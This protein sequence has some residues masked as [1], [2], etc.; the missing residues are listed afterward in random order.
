MSPLRGR[1]GR[2]RTATRTFPAGDTLDAYL[3]ST[4]DLARVALNGGVVPPA[5]YATVVPQPGDEIWLYPAWAD[6]GILLTLGIGLAVSLLAAT[7]S[8]FLFRPKPLLL[9]QQN[10]MTEA[11]EERTF[12][13]EGIRTAIG[14][15]AVVPV[16]Y[17]RHRI[18][19]QLLA[20]AVD[21]AAVYVDDHVVTPGTPVT[22]VNYGEPQ[23]IVIVTAPGH[24]FQTN[25]NVTLDGLIGKPALN[26][27]WTIRVL[28]GDPDSFALLFSWGVNIETPYGGGGVARPANVGARTVQAI[29]TPP[30]LSL[31]LGLCE[32]PIS[33]VLT[34]TIQINGQPIQNFPGVQVF[35][36]LGTA[37][38]PAFAEFGAPRNTFSDGRTLTEEGIAVTYTSNGPLYA[39]VLNVV[40]E[41]GLFFMNQKGEK[42]SNTV[43]LEYRYA[44]AGT[45]NWSPVAV[46][47]VTGDRTAPV[48][49]GLKQENLPFAQYD[50]QIAR[51]GATQTDEVRAKFVPTLE[52]VT[53]YIPNTASYPYTAWLG[54][55]ALATDSLR[56][57]LPN[58]TVEVLGR[59]VRVATLAPVATWSDNPSWCIMDMLTN[60]RYGRGVSDGEIDLNAF[61]LYALNCDQIIDG[62]FR[63]RLNIVLDRET[64]AQQFFLE[65]MGGSRG[66]LLKSYG[67]WTP[68]PTL[69]EPPVMLL[70][71]TMVSN[72]TLT[73]LRDV[74]AI[75]VMEA[76]FANEDA[77]FEQDVLTWPTIQNWPPE[78]HKASL[79]L[80]GV[81]KPSR[82]MRA[83]QFELNRR[84]YEN[85]LLELD[86]SAEAL[87]LQIHDLFRFSHPLPGWGTSGRT[88]PGST[89]FTL[90]LDEPCTFEPGVNYVVY[91]RYENDV[92]EVRNVIPTVPSPV[93]A[94]ILTTP[95]S[96]TPVP[97]TT[98]WVFGRLD[99]E[100]N[101]RIF[102]VTALQRKSDTTVHLEAVI[103]NP[104]IYDDPLAAPL[105]VITTLFNPLGPP[106]PLVTL[107]ATEVTRI[108]ASGASLRVVNLSWDIAELGSGL[109][110][111]G[112]AYIYRRSILASG[113]LGQ[114]VAGT[115]DLGAIVDANDPNV[116]YV[117]LAQVRG[118]VLDWDDATVIT[119]GTYQYR[120]VPVS[121]LGVP[122]N[123]GGREVLIHVAGPTTPGYFPGTPRNL[124]LKGQP[125]GVVFWEGRDCHLEWDPV[126]TSLLFSETFFVQDYIVQIWAP[127]QLYLMRATTVPVSSPGQSVQWSYTYEQN[128]EDEVRGGFATARRDFEVWVWARTN[129]GLL[130]QTPASL[131]VANPAPDM[132]EIVPDVTPLFE[133][134][135]I[136]FNQYAEP[137]DFHHYEVHLDVVNPPVV[138][139][140][141]VS[142]AFRKLFPA[143]LTAGTQ[144]W[145]YILPYDTF[146]PGIASQTATFTPV[147]L[148]ADALDDTPPSLPTGLT[149]TTGSTVNPDGTI[150]SWVRASWVA[151]PESDVA[152]YE[153]HFRIL[154]SVVPTTFQLGTVTSV[155]LE[156]VP[157]QVT[158]ACKLAAFDQFHNVSAFTEE[159]TIVTAA[160]TVPPGLPLSPV[161]HGSFRAIAILWTPPA[162]L[163]YQGTEVWASMVNDRATALPV[164]EDYSDF[165]HEGLLS[166]QTW[167]YWLRAKDTS[168]NVSAFTPG[169][170]AGLTATTAQTTSADIGNLSITAT[171]I[172]DNAISTPKLQAN[173]VDANKV[174]TG[175]LITLGAQI[176]NAIIEDAH[177]HTLSASKIITSTLTAAVSIGVGTSLF[178]DGTQHLIFVTDELGTVRVMLGKLGPLAA[179]YGL[180]IFNAT[181]QL[182]WNFVDGAQ[183]AGIAENAITASKIVA[184]TITAGHL[185]TDTAVIT[186]AA[187]IANAL[188]T[189][190]HI[191]NLSAS[192]IAAGQIAVQVSVGGSSN[193][194][195]SNIFLDGINRAIFI[196]DEASHER[197]R[198]GKLGPTDY[199]LMIW[200][201]AGQ[202]MWDFNTGAQTPGIADLSITNAKIG[203][204][205]IT[206]AKIGNLEVDS[207]KIANLTVGTQK[208]ADNAV[209][210]SLQFNSS[211]TFN[212]SSTE[213]EISSVTFPVLNPGDQVW[214]VGMATCTREGGR[215]SLRI[216]EDATT[217]AQLHGVDSTV[218]GVAGLATQAVW[219][220]PVFWAPKK[221]VMTLVNSLTTDN[222]TAQFLSLV[223]LRRQ[224]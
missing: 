197:V 140:Q 163:D 205:Q 27:T 171:Q 7:A 153:V 62:E 222:V 82:V 11:T 85:M 73:Y 158:V 98:L 104:S 157:G 55:K 150:L 80:R 136:N 128:Y 151:V 155:Q 187:Q 72:V 35:T 212:A 121:A 19:G 78:V 54:L 152:G 83:M 94:L 132:S 4:E 159:V 15:G 224:K 58:I 168:G 210:E 186:V 190:A 169:D 30:T 36:A 181:G 91:V 160:D 173:S 90:V 1:D 109:A 143:D 182:M 108:Q 124:R 5:R 192:K 107:I 119:G 45:G 165:V 184:G 65:T 213:V 13:F 106:P 39:F 196:F 52:S 51:G 75:N 101:T 208:I 3:P 92:V 167:Y 211:G 21:Q 179:H 57:A 32:G 48:R 129:T 183:T 145:T 76:R 67:L 111:Y 46:A 209:T 60:P 53:E 23:N 180:Q 217:G 38:Q 6:G 178:L 42:E 47:D 199:G 17:G 148:T 40:W 117:P 135:L 175:E 99:S 207:A 198:L 162:D 127:A 170:L 24:P 214:I 188:I 28:D 110:P 146:G 26:T 44:L 161:T 137:R 87:P 147:A 138:I 33:A 218:D 125:V 174:T 144:Y 31:F 96:L 221:F 100:A 41:Q 74:D 37:D 8:H 133:A 193:V 203:N 202:L 114:V 49:I 18:G 112:G 2:W 172:A 191:T 25:Q 177:I 118:H 154:P 216:R 122:N 50:I 201:S 66:L 9:P 195:G 204:A 93:Y 34:E 79:D 220:A 194:F 141:D 89:T 219:T 120:V 59:T 139:Y 68:R 86:A 126:E 16:V 12:S 71:W 123:P 102:R 116:S 56:G 189:D 223:A 97:H 69:S 156:N 10:T 131:G 134:A 63:H 84:R 142:I 20:A 130:S 103:H 185:R 22:A 176:R 70:S 81:T 95:L 149:L 105:P 206:N 43:H 77:D 115:V 215:V 113:Q 61:F 200:N 166:L 29:A 14:P 164:G 64:R 88:Q